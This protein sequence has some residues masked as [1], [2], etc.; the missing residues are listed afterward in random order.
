MR[1]AR[2]YVHRFAVVGGVVGLLQLAGCQVVAASGDTAA[3]VDAAT[4]AVLQFVGDFARQA[5][6]AF[7][8]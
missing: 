5:L 3:S 8:F 7:L 4:Q 1:D 6:A 2:S